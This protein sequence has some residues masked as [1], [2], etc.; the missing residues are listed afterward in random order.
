[1]ATSGGTVQI[2]LGSPSGVFQIGATIAIGAPITALSAGDLDNNGLADLVVGNG[3]TNTV[4]TFLNFNGVFAALTSFGVSGTPTS[5]SLGNANGDG[6]LD[7][8]VGSSS[9]STVTIFLNAQTGA[10]TP[11]SSIALPGPGVTS[12]LVLASP[13]SNPGL[14]VANGA[15]SN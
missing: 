12:G 10:L 7:A 13:T 14:A 8:A 1:V 11:V 15:G 5:I 2:F 9:S 3:A 6:F 4:T